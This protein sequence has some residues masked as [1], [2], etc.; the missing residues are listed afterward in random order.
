MLL[1][2]SRVSLLAMVWDIA[3]LDRLVV[4]QWIS[5]WCMRSL[6]WMTK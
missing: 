1:S 3:M 6:A 5:M 4:M 2:R